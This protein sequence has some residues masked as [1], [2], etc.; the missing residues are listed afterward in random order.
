[1][2]VFKHNNVGIRSFIQVARKKKELTKLFLKES[3]TKSF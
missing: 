3:V 1:M 2:Q